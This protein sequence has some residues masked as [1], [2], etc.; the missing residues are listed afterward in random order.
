MAGAPPLP[1][2]ASSMRLPAP[3]VKP[4]SLALRAVRSLG[5]SCCGK[6]AHRSHARRGGPCRRPGAATRAAPTAP[7]HDVRFPQ[8]ELSGS[9]F[10]RCVGSGRPG[11]GRELAWGVGVTCSGGGW[12]GRPRCSSK[13]AGWPRWR[14]P[15]LRE[16]LDAAQAPVGSSRPCPSLA[17]GARSLVPQLSHRPGQL[18]SYKSINL[19]LKPINAVSP[20][21]GTTYG[22]ACRGRRGIVRVEGFMVGLSWGKCWKESRLVRPWRFTAGHALD[23]VRGR[24]P[25]GRTTNGLRKTA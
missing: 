14:R 12:W 24:P 6:Q 8:Q 15:S 2:T 18:S 21:Q 3:L 25:E 13:A 20:C 10:S 23:S 7:A 1:A 9:R 19:S 17:R 22:L 16:K 11:L 5:S 4:Q